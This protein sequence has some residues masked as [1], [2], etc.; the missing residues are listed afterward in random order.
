MDAYSTLDSLAIFHLLL[1]FAFLSPVVGDAALGR[2][3]LAMRLPA[4]KG[5]RQIAP[6]AIPRM[7]QEEDPAL[8][9]TAQTSPQIGSAPQHRPQNHVILL[10][11]S[12]DFAL[13]VPIWTELEMLLD[14]D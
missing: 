8:P 13:V 4:A 9:A 1:R 10:H 7:G 2:T 11:Q 12:T 3:L 6:P 14:L 5:T